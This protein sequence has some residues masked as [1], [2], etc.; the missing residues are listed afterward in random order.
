M[1]FRQFGG[2]NY[3]AK[4]NIVNSNYN[5]SNNLQVTQNV[6]QPSSYINFLSDIIGNI[7]IDISGNNPN[8]GN[9]T[10]GTGSFTYLSASQEISASGG[11]TG[12]VGYFTNLFVAG[13][14]YNIPGGTGFFS[15]LTATEQI[16]APAGITGGTGSF[17]YLSASEQ[18]SAP[19]G[20]TGGT[21]YFSY[22]T[23]TTFTSTSDYRIK[24]NIIPLNNTFIVDN[25]IPVTY[26]N[27]ETKKQDI[28]L[29]AHEVQEH[30]PILVTGEKDGEETQTINYIGLIPI[31]I[32][33]IKELKIRIKNLEDKIIN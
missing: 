28:G 26:K 21:G 18:I 27:I 3:A 10:G 23:A 11:I 32:K 6:G 8:T 22:L 9:I 33:E 29:I 1:S 14:P 7:N 5:T 13:Q 25:L 19:G 2:L 30:F 15:Y 24:E 17:T 16:S 20:I 31:L 12:S 4:H